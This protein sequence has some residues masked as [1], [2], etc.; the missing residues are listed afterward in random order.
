MER[1]FCLRLP[2]GEPHIVG[3]R[4]ISAKAPENTL[5]AFSM[6]AC[7]EGVDMIELDVRL[8]K[9]EEVVVFHDRTLQ[10]TTT[11]N[12][13]VR[14]YTL[15]EIKQFDAGSWFHPSFVHE[16]VPTLKEV[17]DLVRGRLWVNIEIKSD[18]FHREPEGLLETKVLHVIEQCGMLDQ[19]LVSSFDHPLVARFKKLCPAVRTG[20]LYNLYV[21]FTKSPSSIAQ[22]AHASAFI[23]AKHEITRSMVADAKANSIAVYVYTLNSIRD[24]ENIR[25]IGVDGIMSNRA[26]DIVPAH[27]NPAAECLEHEK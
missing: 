16:R 9:D 2:N 7:T 5:A 20:V 11:G 26:D 19:V 18:Y 17:L 6:A 1:P 27:R 3:H 22:Q 8:T 24:A 21:D 14:R 25:A 12:G 15:Q 23:C 4:G 13:I 10:R